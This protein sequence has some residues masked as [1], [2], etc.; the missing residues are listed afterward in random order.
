MDIPRVVKPNDVLLKIPCAGICGSDI[1]CIKNKWLIKDNV[2]LGHE[3]AGTVVDIGPEVTNVKAGDRVTAAAGT[4]CHHCRFCH[5]GKP[6][7]C[8]T[9]GSA[10]YNGLFRDGAWADYCLVENSQ[11]FKIS[12]DITFE[13]G[14]LMEPMSCVLHSFSI[15]SPLQDSASILIA[16]SGIIGLL[17]AS[18]L[19]YKGFR[20][21]TIC[22]PMQG[23]R[24]IAKNCQ[25]SGLKVADPSEIIEK[26]TDIDTSLDGYDLIFDSTGSSK[27]FEDYF[28]LLR[29]GATYMM[30]GICPPKAKSSISPYDLLNKEVKILSSNTECNTHMDAVSLAENMAR[31]GKLDLE[32]LGVK[33]YPLEKYETA[34]KD[35]TNA[36][37]SKA[38][39][40]V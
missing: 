33:S 34:L 22:E 9:G 21:I 27:A 11:L 10:N 38:M 30:F 39:L 8:P 35:L 3:F 17:K 24:D 28:P 15:Y 20:D 26:Y 13:V 12:D 29:K 7:L 16:G 6:H 18:V 31:D 32:K 23:R 37:I 25:L 36:T 4:H 2:V 14:A 1:H 19:H 40:T 5:R